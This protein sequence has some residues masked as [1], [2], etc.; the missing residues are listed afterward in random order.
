MSLS[1]KINRLFVLIGLL[2]AAHD[3]VKA[4][5][6]VIAARALP[7]P[8]TLLPVAQ[9]TGINKT[10]PTVPVPTS[11]LLVAP[12]LSAG[13]VLNAGAHTGC[14][15]FLE[16]KDGCVSRTGT[17]NCQA[18]TTSIPIEIFGDD[19]A[20]APSP[21]GGFVGQ[22][23]LLP[24][25]T[26]NSTTVE[27]G[28]TSGKN[29]S[30][31]LSYPKVYPAP[32]LDKIRTRKRAVLSPSSKA[33]SPPNPPTGAQ[34]SNSSSSLSTPPPVDLGSPIESGLLAGKP[35]NSSSPEVPEPL[36]DA[37]KSSPSP[38][39]VPADFDPT[40]KPSLGSGPP[41]PSVGSGTSQGVCGPYKPEVDA[42]VCVWSGKD[43]QGSDSNQSG[44]FRD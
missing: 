38:I 36:P 20:Q 5:Q 3:Q 40:K 22:G 39:S 15:A 27:V 4:T 25:P 13:D 34:S 33:L 11:P 23:S 1:P 18:K 26:S 44:W 19:S 37:M 2:L 17:N 31:G 29:A 14:Y 43:A 6:N 24:S 12:T 7:A 8:P 41:L 10:T 32:A 16:K 21:P 30:S 9:S 35:A 42:G 28:T